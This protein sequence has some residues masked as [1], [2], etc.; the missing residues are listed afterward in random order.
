MNI[1]QESR[2]VEVFST[3]MLKGKIEVN[4]LKDAHEYIKE[5]ASNPNPNN[6]YEIAQIMSFVINEGLSQRVN[7]LDL[8]ADVKRTDID[9][10]AR[11]KTEIDGLKA[12]FQ[13]KSATTERSKVS[14]KYTGLD[15]E[16]VSIRPV[17]DF[18]ELQTG[19]ANL[20]DLAQKAAIKMEL[21]IVKRI[22]DSVYAAFKG[23]TGVN[24]ASGSGIAKQAFDPILFAMARAGGST[25][26]VG[27]TEALAKFT[28][29]TGFDGN[30]PADL[31][32]E[33][34]QNGMIGKYN[35]SSLVKLNNPFQAG[36]LTETELRKDLVYVIPNVEEGLKPIKVQFAGGVQTTDAPVSIDSKQVEFR[37][38]QYI[39]AGVI[40]ARKLLGVYEDTTLSE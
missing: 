38:D 31:A 11:F 34:N 17:V 39:G 15:T 1:N 8:I 23:T 13:A 36:S 7:Y 6:R 24:Y 25:S 33:H 20:T 37:F 16:E 29:L 22:Q 18:L 30:V 19:K 26:I 21:A 3:D 14:S 27:D 2:I 28:A 4:E 12:M 9:T 32:A 35:G 5:L 10:K 40:G